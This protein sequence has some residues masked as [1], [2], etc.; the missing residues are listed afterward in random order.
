M[1]K[2]K[3]HHSWYGF[4]EAFKIAHQ[5]LLI[6]L[7]CLYQLSHIQIIAYK[8]KL[9]VFLAFFKVY[10]NSFSI[11]Y[12]S[13][14]SDICIHAHQVDF[15]CALTSNV[16]YFVQA[17]N[18]LT[19]DRHHNWSQLA[20]NIFRA[21]LI[22][23]YYLRKYWITSAISISCVISLNIWLTFVTYLWVNSSDLG[24]LWLLLKNPSHS[25]FVPLWG[26]KAKIG[27][28]RKNI[29]EQNKPSGGLG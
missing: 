4:T 26:K 1:K 11:V 23:Y 12:T 2:V 20:H 28:N 22:Y 5:Y 27:W 9:V 24:F 14:T 7:N 17:S 16:V 8:C 29:G 3:I 25:W 15:C 21:T 18:F 6:N 19:N 10:V 13:F